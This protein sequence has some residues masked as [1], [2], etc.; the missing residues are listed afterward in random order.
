MTFL[1][2]LLLLLSSLQ[3]YHT[4]QRFVL[5]G[6]CYH[7]NP[8]VQGYFLTQTSSLCRYR[9]LPP[10]HVC[11][12]DYCRT[13]EKYSIHG[14]KNGTGKCATRSLDNGNT[15][16]PICICNINHDALIGNEI[17]HESWEDHNVR[18]LFVDQILCNET[19]LSDEL[20]KSN[21]NSTTRICNL[22]SSKK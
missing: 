14:L 12:S 8:C 16:E 13:L 9:M 1:S 5:D 17:I 19:L 11:Q 15:F 3:C 22:L 10:N 18:H 4:L 7:P 6:R 21:F 20:V 2:F